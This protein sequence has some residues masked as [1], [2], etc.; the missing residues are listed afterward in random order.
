MAIYELV[1]SHVRVA[2]E[3]LWQQELI[4]YTWLTAGAVCIVS[5]VYV[6][7]CLYFA[8]LCNVPGSTLSKLTSARMNINGLLGKLGDISIDEY[9]SR[10]DIFVLTPNLVIVSNPTDCRAI[11]NNPQFVKS[12][13][14]K[15]FDGHEPNLLSMR[16]PDL[17]RLRRKQVGPAFANGYLN[18]MEPIILE[19][20]INALE[21]KWDKLIA[22]SPSGK[23]TINYSKQFTL[24]T[25]DIIGALGF[26]R[27]FDSLNDEKSRA[28]KWVHDY[29]KLGFA[30]LV[31]G[32]PES[33]LAKLF[34]RRLLKS[35][36]EFM[37]FGATVA[38]KR[39]EQLYRGDFEKPKDLL[40]ILIDA[41][42]P[43][44]KVPMTDS[45]VTD[46]SIILLI[47]GADTMSWTLTW[48]LHYLLLHPE[49]YRKVTEEVRREFTRRH[50]ITYAEGKARLP[51]LDACIYE[52]M[53][54]QPVSGVPM[55]RVVPKGGA[56]IQGHFL[57]EGTIA[58]VCVSGVNHHKG[59]WSNPRKFMPERFLDDTKLKN[60]VLT[61]GSGVRVCPGRVMALYEL[62]TILANLLKDYDFALPADSLFTPS[63]LDEHGNPVVMPR[64]QSFTV[65]PRYPK[66]D[67]NVLISSAPEY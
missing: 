10:G 22:G 42:H 66:R 41:Q 15:G 50:L 52:S 21:K 33:F 44:C 19:C 47:G 59:T 37:T 36:E 31:F 25:F 63:R 27:R 48:T 13:M 9:Y 54:I 65:G 55:P 57:P 3:R 12:D 28:V 4:P 29:D 17:A 35:K 62:V 64:F 14:Y 43:D 11:L 1:L 51:Y 46:N 61:F 18:D 7:Y 26:G 38:E 32:G 2:A 16:S 49:V 45:Q 40:Q 39:R 6:V 23:A 58:C 67:C 56:T 24:A 60:N 30:H 34:L 5:I 20:G 8:P 53:R